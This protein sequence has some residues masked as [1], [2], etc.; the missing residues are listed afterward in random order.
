MTAL[1]DTIAASGRPL[2]WLE[3]AAYS[4]GLLAA[5]N[6]PWLDVSAL[7][8]WQRK[9][10]GLLRPDVA[11]LPLAPLI[12]AWLR[13]HPQLTEAMGEKRRALYPLKTLLAD[14]ALRAHVAEALSGLRSCFPKLPLA[15][16]MPSP[17]RWPAQAY[18]QAMGSVD[19]VEIGADEIDSAAMYIA[20][21][22]RSFGE[23]GIDALLLE[24]SPE[25]V[26][27][28][29][30][31][32][33][34]YRPLLNVCAHYRWSCGLRLPRADGKL[35]PVE[36]VSFIIAPAVVASA[37][38]GI[39]VPDSFWNDGIVP[40]CPPGGFRFAEITAGANPETVLERLAALR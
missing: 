13:Q 1:L 8:A 11:T 24:E 18:L 6:I 4:G 19:G 31:E 26:P 35:E 27:A 2:L 3:H 37:V 22:L 34:W 40:Q 30:G 28:S 32:I 12:D 21:F 33:E 29:A 9:A 14:E 39:S 10:Q 5:G 15:L 38:A 20:D 16:V 36:G 23:S 7:V 25:A 17:R